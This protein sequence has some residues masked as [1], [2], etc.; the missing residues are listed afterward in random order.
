M[1]I[2]EIQDLDRRVERLEELAEGPKDDVKTTLDAGCAALRIRKDAF[3]SARKLRK[4]K[5]GDMKAWLDTFDACREA[6]GYDA[7]IDLVDQIN[8]AAEDERAMAQAEKKAGR[9]RKKSDDLGVT[10]N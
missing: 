6:F 7:Q 2:N 10:L 8:E 5:P 9:R 4:L 1:N 3:K